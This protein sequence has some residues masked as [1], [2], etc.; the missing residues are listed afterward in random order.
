MLESSLKW[1]VPFF[2]RTHQ[3]DFLSGQFS[4]YTLTRFLNLGLNIFIQIQQFLI[5]PCKDRETIGG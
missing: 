3:N 5:L 4:T 1:Q 2:N